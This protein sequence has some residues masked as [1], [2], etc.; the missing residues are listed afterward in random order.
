MTLKKILA[1]DRPEK[2]IAIFLAAIFAVS[3]ISLIV[4]AS[5][6]DVSKDTFSRTITDTLLSVISVSVIGTLVSLLLAD[7]NSKKSALEKE[8]EERKMTERNRDEYR[9]KVLQTIDE[10]YAKTKNARRMLR[11]K[12]FSTPYYGN[13]DDNNLLGL[14]FYDEAMDNIND[15]QLE[16]EKI[17]GEITTNKSVF[18]NA[19]LITGN[20]KQ[21]ESYLGGLISEYE[22]Y[23]HAFSGNPPTLRI[24]QLG[25]LKEFIA[26]ADST[27][28]E[29]FKVKFSITCNKI[30]KEIRNDINFLV[31]MQGEIDV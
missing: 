25:D 4:V 15:C 11:A 30:R 16:L 24:G 31:L 23:R 9:K 28:T 20:L 13:E 22:K 27:N 3:L 12:G 26:K 10:H 1:W 6:Y 18:S 7:Y 21:M 14:S 17:K 2:T 29:G 8:R 5:N 19:A